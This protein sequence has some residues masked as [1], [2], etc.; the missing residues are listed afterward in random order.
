Y[1]DLYQ[2]FTIDARTGL[3]ADEHTPERY[4]RERVYLVLPQEARAWAARNGIE[5][6]P[7]PLSQVARQ[8]AAV[9]FLTPDP[10]TIFQLTPLIPREAQRIKLSAA[11]PSGTRAVSYWL[12]DAHGQ[13]R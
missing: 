5:P 10:H 1:D 12:R 4:R 2:L 6:P 7:V 11:V 13:E 9:R 8:V 3:L